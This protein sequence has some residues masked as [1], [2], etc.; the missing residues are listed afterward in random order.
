MPLSMTAYANAQASHNWGTL[1]WEIRSV[2]HRYLEPSFHLPDTLRQL[3]MAL[4]E[5]MTRFVQRGKIDCTLLIKPAGT[6]DQI[7]INIDAAQ[8]YIRAGETIAQL[9]T[10]PALICPMDILEKPGVLN[11]QAINPEL[12]NS[13]VME[14][15]Q[16]AMGQVV[17]ARE[18]EGSKLAELVRR[19]LSDITRHTDTVR[20]A[21]PELIAAQR[22]KLINKLREFGE[23]LDTERLEQE[24]VF[25]AQKADV[26]EE[27]DRLGVHVAEIYHILDSDKAM[28][29]RLDFL[30]Q[31][32]NREANT[33]SAK[34]SSSSVSLSAVELKVLIEQIREQIQNLE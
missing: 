27:L 20:S 7:N 32:L 34:S 2:N 28:G 9:I 16:Q 13:A 18:R 15:Y 25:L 21:M 1:S 10:S 31:E 17:E 22:Q 5:Q 29:R 23:Q 26:D 6:T 8:E 3:E 14:L 33:L 30:V 11:N 12:L 4:L 24:L 19:R